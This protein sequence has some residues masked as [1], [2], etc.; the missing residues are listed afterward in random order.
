MSVAVPIEIAMLRLTPKEMINNRLLELEEPFKVKYPFLRVLPPFS[1]FAQALEMLSRM[2]E[3]DAQMIVSAYRYVKE[4]TE[5][6]EK[7]E[8]MV[9]GSTFN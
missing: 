4:V 7:S 2:D 6:A 3:E 5:V 9:E 1:W 8:K